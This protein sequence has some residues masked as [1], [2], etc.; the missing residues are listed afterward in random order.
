MTAWVTL[1][2]THPT[3]SFVYLRL[4]TYKLRCATVAAFERL[5]EHQLDESRQFMLAYWQR[6]VDLGMPASEARKVA[7]AV[8]RYRMAKQSKLAERLEKVRTLIPTYWRSLNELPRRKRT[9]YQNQKR[10]S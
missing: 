5:S 2:L 6:L 1:S 4:S 7:R 9:G 10:A 3:K 8:A